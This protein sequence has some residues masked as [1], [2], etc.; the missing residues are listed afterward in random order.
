MSDRF[1]F[2]LAG[3]VYSVLPQ[4]SL[5]CGKDRR[6][7][8]YQTDI[9]FRDTGFCLTEEAL[10]ELNARVTRMMMAEDASRSIRSPDGASEEDTRRW[11]QGLY[12]Q[13]VKRAKPI[14]EGL[15][16]LKGQKY[17]SE[18][19]FAQAIDNA[20]VA[21]ERADWIKPM[22]VKQGYYNTIFELVRY[23]NPA[24]RDCGQFGEGW[25][26]MI[27]Y[28]ISPADQAKKKFKGVLV[29][30]RMTVQNLVNGES[31]TLTF[32]TDHYSVAGYVPDSVGK[33]QVVGLFLMTDASFRLA[34]KLGNEFW[35]DP[36]GHLTDMA[37][38]E[39]HR[40]RFEYADGFIDLFDQAPYRIEPAGRECVEF[41]GVSIPKT[42]TVVDNAHNMKETLLFDPNGR[43][44]GYVPE[45]QATTRFQILA[46]MSDVSFRLLDRNGN[47]AAFAP[48]GRFAGFCPSSGTPIVKSMFAGPH[49]VDFGYTMGPSGSP[50]IAS[51]R[52]YKEVAHETVYA[53][54]YEYDNEGRLC[55]TTPVQNQLAQNDP[56]QRH[57]KKR[58]ES[59]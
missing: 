12:D 28:R 50:M 45:N 40:I 39:H 42:M 19:E 7:V 5:T 3:Q 8:R 2:D 51:A 31:E 23:F 57:D 55:K 14:Q 47:E 52:L 33:S 16:K 11:C 49:K 22:V 43:I 20:L 36:A 24:Q 30:E 27:P 25:R 18:Q 17:S 58:K 56:F 38:S 54:R 10:E 35:F 9:A 53:V 26:L 13:A 15:S 48:D 59:S 1:S 29:P 46:L 37:F 44:V 21:Q 32:S 6:G 34:D 4:H 41:Q